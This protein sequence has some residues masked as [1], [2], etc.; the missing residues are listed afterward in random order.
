MSGAGY[1]LDA[2]ALIEVDRG[3]RR[4]AFLLGRAFERNARLTIPS[5][6]LAQVV[7][8]P[9]RQAMLMRLIRHPGVD[10]ATLDEVAAIRVGRLLAQSATSDVVDAHVVSCAREARQAVI[11]SDPDDLRRLDPHVPLFVL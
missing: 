2:G 1:T 10:I 5:T 11:T 9:A 7:R 6:V 3:D 8:S 4:M